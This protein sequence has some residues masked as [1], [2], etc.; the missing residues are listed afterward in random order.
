MSSGEGSSN[1]ALRAVPRTPQFPAHHGPPRPPLVG[2]DEDLRTLIGLLD[3]HRLITVTGTGGVGKT[4]LASALAARVA[5]QLGTPTLEVPLAAVRQAPQVL[6]TVASRAGWLVRGREDPFEVLVERIAEDPALVVLDNLE[7]VVSVGPTLTRWIDACPELRLVVTSRTPLRVDGETVFTVEPLA[8]PPAST[9]VTPHTITGSAAVEL[10]VERAR[11]AEPGFRLNDANAADVL[12]ICR[13]LDG[14]PLAIELAAARMDLMGAGELAALIERRPD[15]LRS[16]QRA[17]ADERHRTLQATIEW[18]YD[19]LDPELRRIFRTIAV[20]AGGFRLDALTAVAG[21][22]QVDAIDAL[23][24][25][26]DHGL[27]RRIRDVGAPNAQIDLRRYGSFE[28]IREFALA[29]LV[30]AGELEP[31]AAAHARWCIG[32]VHATSPKLTGDDPGVAMAE[33][34]A[35][36]GNLRAAMRWALERRDAATALAIGSGLW[37]FWW[38]RGASAEGRRWLDEALGIDAELSPALRAAALYARGQ[39]AQEG[40]DYTSSI[41]DLE[42][43]ASMFADLDQ[44]AELAATWNGLAFTR[45]SQGN[46]EAA[47]E[48]HARVLALGRAPGDA[49]GRAV[50]EN[51]LAAVAYYRNDMTTAA[52]RWE[53]AYT[54][55]RELGDRR[56][57]SQALGNLGAARLSLGDVAGATAAHEEG[58]EIARSIGDTNGLLYAL[59]NLTDDH[60]VGGD[61]DEAGERL[62]EVVELADRCGDRYVRAAA[63]VSAGQLALRRGRP[64]EAFEEL[65]AALAIF[66][67]FA[68]DLDVALTLEVLGMVAD[69]AGRPEASGFLRLA[70]GL[71]H[72]TSSSA[73]EHQLAALAAARQRSASLAGADPLPMCDL[74]DAQTAARVLA[75]RCAEVTRHSTS[76]PDLSDPDLSAPAWAATG[77]T[78]REAEVALLVARRATDPEIAATLFISTRTASS[79]VSSVLRK[80]GVRSRRLVARDLVE[81]GLLPPG[82]A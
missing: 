18:S 30:A 73:P 69:S 38:Y 21:L 34:E 82:A 42:R 1:R 77:L 7:Q 40:G 80:L 54:A 63:H 66:R 52:R 56:G 76:A 70:D 19:L 62:A 26:I 64:G 31:T 45:R 48:L 43:A 24:D 51:G 59:A 35:D 15:V 17:L 37:H 75:H 9:F 74:D 71:R 58:A 65:G 78:R 6:E 16:R 49:R 20:F 23:G 10:F 81:R 47:A 5:A 13:H 61:L 55:L 25:L 68:A 8:V 36:L 50:A 60:L 11:H 57:A 67:T 46:L 39:L 72:A 2:R 79:H 28:V 29:E 12:R 4:S 41:A 44:T 22:D 3:E 14:L 32:L 33:L 27:V 53:A